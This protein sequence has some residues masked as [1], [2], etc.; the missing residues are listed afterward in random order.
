MLRAAKSEI[1]MEE[2]NNE[3]LNGNN[4]AIKNDIDNNE[5]RD[6][7]IVDVI[8]NIKGILLGILFYFYNLPERK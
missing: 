8:N 6:S 2:G 4:V 3:L 5:G 7:P 1:P